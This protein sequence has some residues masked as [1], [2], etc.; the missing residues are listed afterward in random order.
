[1]RQSERDYYHSTTPK[2]KGAG[3]NKKRKYKSQPSHTTQILK[4]IQGVWYRNLNGLNTRCIII[5]RH[6][7]DLLWV[8]IIS[9]SVKTVR[10]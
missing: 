7:M 6:R 8:I 10:L 1:M 5:G 2:T 9:A 3:D 4:N